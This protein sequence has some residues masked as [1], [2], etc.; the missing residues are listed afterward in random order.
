MT[1]EKIVVPK[2]EMKLFNEKWNCEFKLRNFAVLRNTFNVSEH[3][4]LT[5]L[6]DRKLE[7]I[8]YGIWA[9]TIVF[10]PFDAADPLKVEKTMDLEKILELSLAE[11][12]A[13]TDQVVKAMEAYLPKPKPQDIAKAEAQKKQL[14]AAKTA[15]KKKKSMK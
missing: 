6:M 5:G 1:L 10:A 12:Q 11:L 14:K 9:S 4:L 7:F 8:A 15:A 13:A 2:L 3:Q